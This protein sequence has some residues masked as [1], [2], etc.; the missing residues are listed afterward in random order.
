MACN[1]NDEGVGRF[2]EKAENGKHRTRS[3]PGSRVV[4]REGWGTGNAIR[5][6]LTGEHRE[7]CMAAMLG[8]S[9]GA[10]AAGQQAAR[11]DN[12]TRSEQQ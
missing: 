2:E 1:T 11:E 7:Y 6:I 4:Q 9:K 8:V 5:L 10:R 3:E 12:A